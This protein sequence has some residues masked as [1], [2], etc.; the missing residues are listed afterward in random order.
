[1]NFKGL[2]TLSQHFAFLSVVVMISLSSPAKDFCSF[3]K[4][5]GEFCSSVIDNGFEREAGGLIR[6]TLFLP[7]TFAST[8]TVGR[9]HFE[10]AILSSRKQT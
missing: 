6:G 4:A 10:M 8:D 7:L 9:S 5:A 3:I 1:M 2:Q